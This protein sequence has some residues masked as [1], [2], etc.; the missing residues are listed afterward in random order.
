LFLKLDLSFFFFFIFFFW[1]DDLILNGVTLILNVDMNAD[2][3]IET[4]INYDKLLIFKKRKKKCDKGVYLKFM[5]NL[6]T[7]FLKL[8]TQGK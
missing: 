2:V 5:Q 3:S 4:H 7:I 6:T 8:K 1:P